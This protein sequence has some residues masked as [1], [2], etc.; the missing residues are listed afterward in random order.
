[1][2]AI[3]QPDIDITS[4]NLLET[5][6]SKD[7]RLGTSTPGADPSGDYAWKLFE[8]ADHLK[9]GSFDILSRKAL[10]LTGGPTSQKPPKD[11]NAYGWVMGENKADIFLTY[12]S[13]AVSAAMD[14]PG[15]QVVSIPAELSVVANYGLLERKG[16]PENA[17]RLALYILSPAGQKIL[18]KYGFEPVAN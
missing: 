18:G 8:R 6:L 17:W 15:I 11:R 5:F 10:L 2:C 3:V 1:M 9:P 4:E 7:I 13:N 12:C 16:A 14:T